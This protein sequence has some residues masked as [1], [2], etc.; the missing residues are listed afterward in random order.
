MQVADATQE[1]WEIMITKRLIVLMACLLG[2]AWSTSITHANVPTLQGLDQNKSMI[3]PITVQA[4]YNADTMFFNIEWVGD[5]G[6][7]HDLL[8]YTNGAWQ[9]EGGP[10]REAQSTLDNDPTRG[11]TNLNSTNY[12]SRVTWMIN[13]P[14][15]PNA[16]TNFSNTGCFSTCH[17]NSRAMPEWD[18]SQN[19]TKYLDPDPVNP[20]AKLDLWHHRQARANPIG[21]SDDQNVI[22]TDGTVGGRKGDGGIGAPYE[23]NNLVD[24]HPTWVLDNTTSVGNVFAY[25]FE[26]TH[27][28]LNHA[29]MRAGDTPPTS[30][31]TALDY[32][33]ALDRGYDP[34]EG[35]TVSR[36]RLR[37][38]SGNERG[39]ITAAGTMFTPDG[40]D[41]HFGTIESST[42]RFLD[43]G[44][45]DDTALYD[46]GVFDIAFGLH[47]GMVTVRDHYVSFPM[48][49]SLGGGDADVEAVELTG[50]G[51]ETLPNWGEI[52]E[53]MINL[54]LPGI[55]S[56]EFL[57]G[58]NVGKEY[59]RYNDPTPV[60][61][62][63]GGSGSV[64]ITSCSVCH[65]VTDAEVGG[66]M[67]WAGAMESLIP[68]RGGVWTP[69]PTLIPEP[70]TLA[71]LGSLACLAGAGLV[72][73]SRR[74][75]E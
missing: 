52:G 28:D 38:N 63:H 24:G 35:D 7:T 41:M 20:D 50:S 43:T 66:G 46:G 25:D 67:G 29:F 37:D 47:T 65:V 1:R 14:N 33:T 8:R 40:P 58:E 64:G 69:T 61:Q 5:R 19:L 4:A 10:R 60:D 54:F 34:N 17:D 31:P 51:R 13:D 59:Q 42:Q 44:D 57:K 48:T 27:T 2:V 75:E 16:V 21:M 23:T 55:A 6:D 56:L 72:F 68:Q 18:P 22:Q 53:T 9:K 39:D 30:I 73:K 32:Q 62:I 36:R 3:L 15:G 70:P 12:E 71:L 26:D 45:I 11:P 74:K 49:L